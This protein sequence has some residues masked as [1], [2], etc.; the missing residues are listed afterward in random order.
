MPEGHVR[1]EVNEKT[2]KIRFVGRYLDKSIIDKLEKSGNW[3]KEQIQTLRD[4]NSNIQNKGGNE[5]LI[6][7]FKAAGQGGGK[8]VNA[9]V[10]NHIEVPYG[11]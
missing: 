11:F 6:S 7:Y 8:Y 2:G 5:Y 4:V 9:K 10:E 1:P 3:N